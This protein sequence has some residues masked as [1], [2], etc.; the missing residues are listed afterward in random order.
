ME[1]R[2]SK[3]VGKLYFFR[4][5]RLQE[6]NQGEKRKVAPGTTMTVMELNT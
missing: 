1:I 3:S 2:L 4:N 6:K 5:N